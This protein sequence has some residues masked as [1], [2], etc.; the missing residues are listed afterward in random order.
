MVTTAY[1]YEKV[2]LV[3]AGSDDGVLYSYCFK[4]TSND[5]SHL[6][7]EVDG[8]AKPNIVTFYPVISTDAYQ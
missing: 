8:A 7:W 6:I 3:Y 2:V 4:G 5:S 1:G